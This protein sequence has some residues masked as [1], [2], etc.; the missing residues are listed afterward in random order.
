MTVS[1]E[2][3][4][5]AT[6]VL[7]WVVALGWMVNMVYQRN[8]VGTTGVHA[9]IQTD[10]VDMSQT[11][12]K[13]ER[14]E[15]DVSTDNL[16]KSNTDQLDWECD[17]QDQLIWKRRIYITAEDEKWHLTKDCSAIPR[18]SDTPLR[19]DTLRPGEIGRPAFMMA[20][21]ICT[22]CVKGA[23]KQQAYGKHPDFD[24]NGCE[25]CGVRF[26]EEPYPLQYEWCKYC[27]A[28][29]SYHHGRCCP[30]KKSNETRM[31]KRPNKEESASGQVQ[32]YYDQVCGTSASSTERPTKSNPPDYR[33]DWDRDGNGFTKKDQEVIDHA[34]KMGIP[35]TYL[36][37]HEHSIDGFPEE[38]SRLRCRPCVTGQSDLVED[39]KKTINPF[40]TL[41][42]EVD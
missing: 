31:R 17:G 6:N 14:E 18:R 30:R 7:I 34:T 22:Q 20:R 26:T 4:N 27:K 25:I 19:A 13:R 23:M 29:P 16:E 36:F 2:V 38:G 35:L 41:P 42:L 11:S 3:W 5:G 10:S 21:E 15:S 9:P 39:H 37:E 8:K 28:T 33:K 24:P 40:A 12:R 32:E 1:V